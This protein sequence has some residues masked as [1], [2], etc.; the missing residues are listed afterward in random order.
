MLIR[1]DRIVI[2]VDYPE[3]AY[4]IHAEPRVDNATRCL[5]GHYARNACMPNSDRGA[6]NVLES[7]SIALDAGDGRDL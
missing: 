7:V 2:R 4:T 6:S 5:R 3:S 1:D